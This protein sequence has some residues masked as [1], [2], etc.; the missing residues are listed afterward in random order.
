MDC[1]DTFD[2]A[3]SSLSLKLAI[4]VSMF[5]PRRKTG[6]IGRVAFW[7]T[8]LTVV[9]LTT[10][11]IAA[12]INQTGVDSGSF[13]QQS[14]AMIKAPAAYFLL[15]IVL[16]HIAIAVAVVFGLRMEK[17]HAQAIEYTYLIL[18]VG[19]LLGVSSL[20][21]DLAKIKAGDV[22]KSIAR[23]LDAFETAIE[24]GL[25]SC[26][27]RVRTPNSGGVTKDICDWFSEA[28]G[29]AN[30]Q[31]SHRR[32]MK[33]DEKRKKILT[34]L[35]A[36]SELDSGRRPDPLLILTGEG[37]LDARGRLQ[38]IGRRMDSYYEKVAE[39]GKLK[40]PQLP[41]GFL[42]VRFLASFGL[43]FAL[44][45]RITKLSAETVGIVSRPP[46]EAER[47]AA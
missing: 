8:A 39:E 16:L 7:I 30:G 34:Q 40:K 24:S 9:G 37:A 14:I 28:D 26:A 35:E 18:A 47:R 2:K 36:S 41:Q 3:R 29:F 15:L 25:R 13:E 5:E 38:E 43:A 19:G 4:L 22:E 31:I 12:T 32:W 44:A 11:L 27:K 23:D 46:V 45:V 21:S 42:F 33:L 10:S 1:T 20:V 6:H 17:H